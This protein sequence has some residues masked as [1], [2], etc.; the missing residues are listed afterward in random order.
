MTR[1]VVI[2]SECIVTNLDFPRHL[3]HAWLFIAAGLHL[4]LFERTVDDKFVPSLVRRIQALPERK[5]R[6]TISGVHFWLDRKP[7]LV[8]EVVSC[9]NRGVKAGVFMS[10][11]VFDDT[12]IEVVAA[13]GTELSP[14]LL[15]SPLFTMTPSCRQ[16][17]LDTV[18]CGPY[19]LR[20]CSADRRIMTFEKRKTNSSDNNGPDVV[21]VVVTDDRDQGLRLVRAR[22]ITLSC[23]LGAE[24][25]VFSALQRENAVSNKMTNL[26]M[27]LCP[28]PEGPLAQDGEALMTIG[29]A[30]QRADLAVLTENTFAPLANISNLFAAPISGE[31][32]NFTPLR[33]EFG[34]EPAAFSYRGPKC[35][36]LRYA[37]FEPN[38]QIACAIQGQL[39]SSIGVQTSLVAV[40]YEE[41]VASRYPAKTGLSLEII[42]PTLPEGAFRTQWNFVD[43]APHRNKRSDAEILPKQQSVRRRAIPL[44]QGATTMI[45]LDP[46]YRKKRILTGEGILNWSQL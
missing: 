8:E 28:Y 13:D 24:P 42:Q 29:R 10:A 46:R 18:T 17:A 15:A 7:V 25:T 22:H 41:Y 1:T 11:Q 32:I 16:P 26:G 43:V 36:E 6:L 5:Y 21:T 35:I 40:A 34:A 2:E 33:A 45:S 37:P 19:S 38:R 12:Q 44:L 20:S 14:Q 23:P 9:L 3:D 31:P 30:L 27:V 4:R 39:Q